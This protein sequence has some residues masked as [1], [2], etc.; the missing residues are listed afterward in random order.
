[1]ATWMI[2]GT[3][4]TRI[5]EQLGP[6]SVPPERYLPGLDR[7]TLERH[8]HWLVP[9]HYLPEANRLLTSVHSWLIR[10]GELNI[11]VDTCGGNHKQRPWSPRYHMLDTPYLQRLV[12]AG[13]APE[14]IDLVMCTHL[15]ADH[16]GWN[17]RLLDGRWVPTFP[18]ARYLISRKEAAWWNP[19]ENHAL[20]GDA[21]AGLYAD[22][23]LPI[24]ERGQAVL[25]DDGYAVCRDAVVE[26]MPGHTPGHMTLVLGKGDSKGIL[27]GDCIHH[28]LQVYL[29]HLN[30]NADEAPEQAAATRLRLLERCAS[31]NVLLFPVHFGAP[32]V[33]RIRRK[34]GSF[35]PEFVEP[36]A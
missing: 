33:V 35:V 11:L 12:E 13:I 29:P 1:M 22:S 30:H 26:A 6:A 36:P 8:M 9:N 28:P 14:Q 3:R 31:E 5:E 4:V 19:A 27:C 34:A 16:V 21:R 7:A 23:V 32:H 10:T 15:H 2:G 25:I 17:T 18:N 24:V 20:V